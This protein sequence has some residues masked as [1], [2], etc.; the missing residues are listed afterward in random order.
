MKLDSK[1][2]A[3]SPVKFV[4]IFGLISSSDP[5]KIQHNFSSSLSVWGES[6]VKLAG[7]ILIFVVEKETLH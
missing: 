2:L 5:G 6:T 3:V 1:S 7:F 4:S